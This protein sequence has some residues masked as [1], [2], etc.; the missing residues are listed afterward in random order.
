MLLKAAT[1]SLHSH[2]IGQNLAT[3]RT[4]YLLWVAMCNLAVIT[5]WWRVDIEGGKPA[6]PAIMCLFDLRL[7]SR[8][9]LMNQNMRV[10][11]VPAF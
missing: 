7:L 8:M 6:V 9:Y 4:E 1:Q 11:L 10:T 2:P 5:E 3:R